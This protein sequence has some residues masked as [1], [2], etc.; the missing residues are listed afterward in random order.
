MELVR[1]IKGVG[2][3][4]TAEKLDENGVGTGEL[5]SC[6]ARG[7]LRR[8]GMTPLPGDIAE[9][10][11]SRERKGEDV[12][13]AIRPRKNSLVRPACANV[14][15]MVLVTAVKD[16]EPDL[17]LLDKLTATAVDNGIDVLMLVNKSDLA[18]PQELADIYQKA[19][20]TVFSFSAQNADE[21][22][23]ARIRAMIT[24]K[25][26]FF[27][28]AS[29]VGKSSTINALYPALSLETGALSEKIARGKHTTRK[30]ELYKLDDT[31]YIADT[32]GFSMLEIAEYRLIPKEHLLSSFPDIE[33]LAG[34]C[35]YKSCT[36]IRE[37]GCGVIGAIGKE[38][39]ASRHESYKLLYEELKNTHEWD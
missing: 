39:A 30:T 20:F 15:L 29:G 7:S 21:G 28:G 27:A 10:E 36:H 14:D 6:R 34:A 12:I 31:T 13:T 17:F 32:P 35:R 33:A 5:F 37:E 25:T 22:T 4:F 3:L 1:I 11:H 26:V 9:V 18:S 38:I 8:E 23:I 2:G 24:G 19:G 16:P